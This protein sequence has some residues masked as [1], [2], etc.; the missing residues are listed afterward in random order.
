LL[1]LIWQIMLDRSSHLMDFICQ[2]PS[3]K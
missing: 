2:S 1:R 3:F